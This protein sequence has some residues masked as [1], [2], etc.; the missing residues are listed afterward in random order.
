[1]NEHQRIMVVNDSQEMRR[2][3]NHTLKREGFDTIAIADGDEALTLLEETRPDMVILDTTLPGSDEL[4][5]L[6]LIRERSNVPIIMLSARYE[7]ESLREALLHGAD[8]FVRWPFS[9]PEFIARIRAKLRRARKEALQP[10]GKNSPA[11]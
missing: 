6:D 2:L 7:V 1:M 10:S 3:L 8:D 11:P 5:T 9:T 4:Q